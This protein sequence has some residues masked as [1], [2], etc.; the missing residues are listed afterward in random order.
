MNNTHFIVDMTKAVGEN[1]RQNNST[2]DFYKR[3]FLQNARDLGLTISGE[4]PPR[5]K[6]GIEEAGHGNILTVGTSSKH[7]VEW[8]RRPQYACE[9]GRT[10]VLDIVDDWNEVNRLLLRYFEEKYQMKLRSGATATVHDGFVK[11]GT[12]IVT[13]DELKK[14]LNYYL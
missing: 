2:M 3:Q 10:P 5:V 9:K 6:S 1:T 7:D 4:N 14:I 8:I 12:E 13:F 11:I